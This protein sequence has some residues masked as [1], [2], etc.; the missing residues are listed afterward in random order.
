MEVNGASPACR[1]ARRPVKAKGVTA[2]H[3]GSAKHV[4]SGKHH[5]PT[6][7]AP[8]AKQVAALAK[9]RAEAAAKAE[10]HA[11]HTVVKKPSHHGGAA[12][13]WSPGLD[14]ASCAFEA[15]AVSLRM[16]GR[17]VSDADVLD[18]YWRV[19]ED[20]D[21][22]MTLEAAL[23]AAAE[24]GLAGVRLLDARPTRVLADG[25]VVGM[26]LEQRHALTVD[27]HGVWTWG[28]WRPV[29][30]GLLLAADEAWELDWDL[31]A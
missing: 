3:A 24:F 30:C 20:P 17:V 13:K 8:T 31:V 16:A 12:A 10:R 29:S 18:A 21:A 27:G 28:A 15:L 22:G 19:T 2:K 11:H 9:A 5:K 23:E 6:K 7:H 1:Y 25:V 26:D 4:A 14:V